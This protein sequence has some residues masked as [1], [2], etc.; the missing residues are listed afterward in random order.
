MQSI[1]I[2]SATASEIAPLVGLSSNVLEGRCVLLSERGGVAIW[3][4]VAGV[5]AA[6]YAYNLGRTLAGKSF[7]LVIGVGI[8]GSY[9]PHLRLG[10]VVAVGSDTF[11]DYGVDDKGRFRSL[12]QIGLLD[13]DFKPY[14]NG[15]LVCSSP[16]CVSSAIGLPVVSGITVASATGSHERIGLLSEL[17]SADTETMEGASLFYCCLMEGVPFLSVRSVSNR[18]EPRDRNRWDIPL[19]VNNLCVEVLRI[20]DYVVGN[21]LGK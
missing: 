13:A 17:Y 2:V 9:N 14:T 10:S 7:E 12:F 8:A 19:A 20:V 3:Y 11:A 1:L 6:P 21:S 4:L 18:V 5:G 16:L 15:V